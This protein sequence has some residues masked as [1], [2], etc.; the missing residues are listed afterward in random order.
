MKK[1]DPENFKPFI[2]KSVAIWIHDHRCAMRDCQKSSTAVEVIDGNRSNLR[3][4]NLLPLCG[5]H[6]F[7][8][9]S[10]PIPHKIARSSIFIM[11]LRK[12]VSFKS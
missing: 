12:A 3:L 10:H 7:Y 9:K 5:H 8:F 11:L 4:D 1:E 6:Y 2:A